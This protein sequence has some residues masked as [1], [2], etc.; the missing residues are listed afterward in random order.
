MR[1]FR[2]FVIASLC[3]VAAPAVAADMP[4]SWLPDVKKQLFT[5]LVSGWYVRG[6]IG[7]SQ[8]SVGSFDVPAPT[9]IDSWGLQNA[10]TFGLG[11]GYKYHWF[12]ADVTVDYANRGKFHGDTAAVPS[13]YTGKIDSFTIL[14]NAYLDLGTWSG[15]TPYIGAGIGTTNLRTH[16]VTNVTVNEPSESISDSTRWNLSYA[17][18]AGIAFRVSPNLVLDVGYRYLV[19]GDAVT[20]PE[21]PAYTDFSYLRDL[22]AHE[23]RIGLRLAL[24]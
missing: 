18:M 13:Y 4:G 2:A 12:R 9:V 6:D 17:G 11:G 22:K 19:M 16:E 3:S 7:Y 1:A 8:Q 23:F 21:P 10:V 24:D 15:F 14:A 20:G 5:E